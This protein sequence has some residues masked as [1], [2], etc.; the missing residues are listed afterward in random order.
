MRLFQGRLPKLG[1]LRQP[2]DRT[3]RV[4]ASG[5][6]SHV[7]EESRR[8]ERRTWASAEKRDKSFDD[9]RVLHGSPPVSALPNV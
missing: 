3:L 6:A 8:L 9:F 7:V 2:R 1:V 5:A 4:S